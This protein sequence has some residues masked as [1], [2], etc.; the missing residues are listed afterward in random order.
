MREITLINYRI[1]FCLDYWVLETFRLTHPASLNRRSEEGL[2]GV[3]LGWVV[4]RAY[5]CCSAQLNFTFVLFCPGH[6]GAVGG[7]K[8]SEG[9]N[10]QR[11]GSARQGRRR[12]HCTRAVGAEATRVQADGHGE[13]SPLFDGCNLGYSSYPMLDELTLL[14][15]C[16]SEQL[17]D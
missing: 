13:G 11:V 6:K 5:H 3:G 2:V 12:A 15:Q 4:D 17:P 7:G 9:Y 1:V 16:V 8:G 10:E 14:P